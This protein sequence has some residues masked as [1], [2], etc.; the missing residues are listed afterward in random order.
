[1]P[2]PEGMW[3]DTWSDI[4]RVAVVGAVAYAVL[5][6]VIRVAGKRTLGR[7]NAF[8]LVVTVALGSVLA[9]ALL[10]SDVSLAEGAVAFVVLA[11]LQFVVALLESRARWFRRVVSARPTIIVRDGRLLE[12]VLRRHRLGRDEVTQAARATGA[13]SLD[14]IA[15]AVLETDGSISVV[16]RD[17]LGDGSALPDR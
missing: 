6:V 3:F 16:T 4:L 1:M 10:S 12:D 13:G 15:V 2:L 9:T 17:R 14:E 11:A 7:F 5:V 8:D